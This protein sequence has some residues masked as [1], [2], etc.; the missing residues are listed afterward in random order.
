MGNDD[1]LVNIYK[2]NFDVK[3]P[4]VADPKEEIDSRLGYMSTPTVILADKK[5]IVLYMH[6]GIIH[7]IDAVLEVVRTFNSK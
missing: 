5:G 3:F 6:E 1:K 2:N 7:D 4:L